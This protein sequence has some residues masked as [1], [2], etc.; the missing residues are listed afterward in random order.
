[1]VKKYLLT[2][3]LTVL[4]LPNFVFA[5]T[6]DELKS[7]LAVLTSQLENLQNQ[8]TQVQDVSYPISL[9][10]PNGGENWQ[11][12]DTHT[13][14]WQPYGYNPDINPSNQVSAYLEKKVNGKFITVG[15]IIPAGNASIHWIGEIDSFNNFAKPGIY[16]IRV[17]NNVT[18]ESDRSD[19]FFKLSAKNTLRANLKINYSDGPLTIPED[20][21]IWPVSWTSNTEGC[22]VYGITGEIA[23]ST[24]SSGKIKIYFSPEFNVGDRVGD[25]GYFINLICKSSQ[26]IEGTAFDSVELKSFIPDLSIENV[27]FPSTGNVNQELILTFD[28]KNRGNAPFLV[29]KYGK[30][31]EWKVSVAETSQRVISDGCFVPVN[32]LPGAGCS[33][34]VGLTFANSGF[35]NGSAVID[36]NN[37]ILD[38]NRANNAFNGI[39]INIASA[40]ST[41]SNI[42]FSVLDIIPRPVFPLANQ[43]FEVDVKVKS[44]TVVPNT[45]AVTVRL[46]IYNQANNVLVYS[47]G[48]SAGGRFVEQGNIATITFKTVEPPTD[49]SLMSFSPGNYRL[50]ADI[51][52]ANNNDSKPYNN[53]LTKYRTLGSTSNPSITVLSPN[54]NETLPLF[55]FYDIKWKQNNLVKISIGLYKDDKWFKWIATDMPVVVASSTYSWIPSDTISV[56][57]VGN[58]FKIYILGYSTSTIN[59]L[60]ED[61][62]DAPFSIVAPSSTPSI[63]VL[64]PNGGESWY[65]ASGQTLKWIST[66]LETAQQVS[67]AAINKTTGTSYNLLNTN[68]TANDGTEITDPG[69]IRSGGI[70]PDGPYVV[71]VGA[72]LSDGTVISDE[73]NMPFKIAAPTTTPKTS[74]SFSDKKINQMANTLNAMKA[75][76]QK[77]FNSL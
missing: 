77:M 66:G 75:T 55:K 40:T 14:L 10:A 29:E 60:I 9:T 18:G 39:K 2:F 71:R 43:K 63:T 28:V 31:V 58:N 64:S 38:S 48:S 50:V 62:S 22:K 30:G 61:K 42:D 15:K 72:R 36:P 53:E 26:L 67:I 20:G 44:D 13:I 17:V 32:I 59:S 65:T 73:S 49:L 4:I 3:F 41:K 1:M 6:V 37:I 54:G 12:G 35:Y 70:I 21:V 69:I 57:E 5:D 52:D 25:R 74:V 16:Y 51:I 45:S 11:I 8:S 7:Q 47:F 19:N 46:N 68:E 23:E 56:N 76:L 24:I 33:V 34:K 27:S